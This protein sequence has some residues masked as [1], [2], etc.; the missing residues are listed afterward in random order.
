VNLI[1]YFDELVNVLEKFPYLRVNVPH[2][3]LHK[4][5]ERRLARLEWLLTRYPNVYTDI[6][7]GWQDFHLQGFESLA[8]HRAR[9]RAWLTRN[10]LKVLFASD[11][12][13]EPRKT[14]EHVEEV[15]RSYMQLLENGPF[16]FFMAP[17]MLMRG[18]ALPD[19]V[20]KAIYEEA[21]ARFLMLDEQG[22]LRDR[23]AGWPGPDD[24]IPGLP[25]Q[26]DEVPPLDRATIPP[27]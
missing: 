12:V 9:S 10:K 21:P 24:E 25:P 15:L 20:L 23:T 13:V 8:A 6:S 18:L 17:R 27:K 2:F 19:E 26:V 4:N 1:K 11:L 22:K 14:P 7:F 5:T 16:R 3:G